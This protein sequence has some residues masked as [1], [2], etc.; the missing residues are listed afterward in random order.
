MIDSGASGY[1]F[2]DST[3]AQS[4]SLP[5]HTLRYPRRLD[6]ADGSPISSGSITHLAELR[7]SVANHH[8]SAHCFVTKLGHYPIILGKA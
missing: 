3:F 6:V 1:A 7:L 8:E 5:L 4:H 2:I